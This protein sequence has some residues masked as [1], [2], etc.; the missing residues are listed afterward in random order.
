MNIQTQDWTKAYESERDRLMDA[1]GKVVDGG[2]VEAIEHIGATSVPGLYGSTCIDIALA[3]WPFPLDAGPA[4]R[5]EALGYK[6]VS[7]YAEGPEQR[8]RHES[9]SFELHFVEPGSEKR[10][11]YVLV[12]DY[13]RQDQAACED[14]SSKKKE[15][16][17][18][19]SKLFEELLPAAH[20]WWIDEY[21][22]TPVETVADE[23]KDVPF[24]WYISGGWALDLFLGCVNRM[25][26]DVDV[27]VPRS[28]QLDLQGHLVRRGWKLITPFEK[29]LEQWPPHMTLESPRHQVHAHR[30]DDFI[31]FLLTEMDGVWKYRREP[32]IIR[33][34]EKASL[35]TESGI[36]YLAPELVLLFKS[37]NTG[38]QERL[39]DQSD[40]EM[41]L[42]HLEP[43]RRAWLHWALVATS[44]DHPWIKQLI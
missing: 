16:G 34:L 7:G 5:L 25:H 32:S 10:F 19:K 20:R 24:P 13:L 38:N 40:F 30:Q 3:V 29:R 37:R 44:P 6:P 4:T 15:S 26:H 2:I 43:E 11:N 12:R 31:D 33:T 14:V 22:F 8:F 42:S 35:R 21:Q 18:D 9:D 39:K 41:A 27:V 23:L 1:L 36:P 17:V 28:A